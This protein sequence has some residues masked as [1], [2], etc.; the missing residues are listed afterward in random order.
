MHF[1]SLVETIT[2]EREPTEKNTVEVHQTRMNNSFELNPI[3]LLALCIIMEF[4]FAPLS[5][6]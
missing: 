4:S 3:L 1:N 6:G 2:R 5:A